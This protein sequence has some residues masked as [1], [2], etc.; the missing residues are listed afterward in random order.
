MQP[1]IACP[2]SQTHL[3]FI[4]HHHSQTKQEGIAATLIHLLPPRGAFDSC[5]EVYNNTNKIRPVEGRERGERPLQ[6]PR[7]G[8]L[9]NFSTPN[10]YTMSIAFHYL[11]DRFAVIETLPVRYGI[12]WVSSTFLPSGRAEIVR[13]SQLANHQNQRQWLATRTPMIRLSKTPSCTLWQL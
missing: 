10:I 12:V 1:S 4:S 5:S 7:N 3:M 2:R 6:A 11:A 13:K 9:L 8:G